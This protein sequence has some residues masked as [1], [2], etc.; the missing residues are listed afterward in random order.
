MATR[1]LLLRQAEEE[2]ARR[3]R[4]D[5][6]AYAY[7]PHQFQ[8]GAHQND[9]D[10]LIVLGGNRSGKSH[11]AMAEALDVAL[12]RQVWKKHRSI[13]HGMGPVVWYI[14]PSIPTFKRAIEPKFWAMVPRK[15]LLDWNK[16]DK[17]ATFRTQQGTI[18]K[19]HFL[20]AEMRQ[21]RLQGASVDLVIMDETPDE[22]VFKEANIR[23]VDRKGRM[24]MV[25]SPIDIKSFWV[26]DKLIVPAQVGERHDIEIVS[27]PVADEDGKVQ[28][29]HLDQE[30]VDRMFRQYPDPADREARIYGRFTSRQ[31][32]VYKQFQ[33]EVHLLPRFR[34]PE[35]WS[36][37]WVVD[38]QYHRFAALQYA[39]DEKGT[40]Y[41]TD[42]YF[43]QDETLSVRA[44]RIWAVTCDDYKPSG[45][46]P[47]YVDSANPQDIAELNWH[48]RRIGAKL[49]AI[50]LP[51]QK[52]IDKMLLRSQSLLETD[53]DRAYPELAGASF[54]NVFG[55]PRMFIFE[56]LYSDWTLADR[57]MAC[58]RLLWEITHMAWG[59]DNKPD[60][61][62]ADGADCCDCFI[63]GTSILSK[64][65]VERDPLAWT[66]G[67]TDAD[68]VIRLA[69]KR[70]ATLER[71]NWPGFDT[72]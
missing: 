50:P 53:E 1:E 28:V 66:K 65:F 41:V 7:G 12:G 48:F 11:F 2:L 43:S 68:I 57:R 10:I 47:L 31:G 63:Y 59:V 71:L 37:F 15:Y 30:D 18:S 5:P 58:S 60:K 22:D 70:M 9:A 14:M 26:R 55:A 49:G 4:E 27:M 24:I 19:L 8:A 29:P 38:P 20:S 52:Q 62:S 72:L 21:I 25:F 67:L 36:R 32:L 39:V 3:E 6:L 34:I 40:Y 35:S 44:A 17:V 69:E 56:D 16:Q 42:E 33:P 23:L 51:M 46:L 54:K 13:R 64:G 61:K 45:S